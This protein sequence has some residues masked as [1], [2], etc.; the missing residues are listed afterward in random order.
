MTPR[1]AAVLGILLLLL[2]FAGLAATPPPAV[3]VE[4]VHYETL[5]APGPWQ[6]VKQGEIEVVEVFAYGCHHCAD[7]APM[8]EAWKAKQP[9]HVRVRYVSATYDPLARGFFAAQRIGALPRTHLATFRALHEERALP[10]NASDDELAAYYAGL[11]VDAKKFRA[12]LDGPQVAAD[13]Q[14]A[15]AFTKRIGLQGTP[16]LIVA[17]RWRMLGGSLDEI[18]RNTAALVANPPAH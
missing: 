1:F 7:L 6:P 18:L 17:G 2:P 5:D 14:A 8:L 9:K 12:A 15:L 11:G 13:M 3:P 10:A 16:T 4:G